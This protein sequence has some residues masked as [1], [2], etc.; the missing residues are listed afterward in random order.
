MK[1]TDYVKIVRTD[2]DNSSISRLSVKL[3]EEKIPI[4]VRALYTY[5]AI[6]GCDGGSPAQLLELNK[7]HHRCH[8]VDCPQFSCRFSFV[9]T[10]LVDRFVHVA[11]DLAAS[12]FCAVSTSTP[13]S[14]MA[15]ELVKSEF[16]SLNADAQDISS[17]FKKIR[18][19]RSVSKSFTCCDETFEDTWEQIIDEP[20]A[21][22]VIIDDA[23]DGGRTA[24]CL[25]RSLYHK[26]L[27][28]EDFS[29]VVLALYSM[30]RH[31]S[32]ANYDTGEESEPIFL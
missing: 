8:S 21:N 18:P 24:A 4:E 31:V 7:L 11:K 3:A 23:V 32:P 30:A 14:Q 10:A 17:G 9:K 5:S 1:N 16:S 6:E 27:F 26:S 25:T 2:L 20:I 29:V 22:L 13:G 19:S 28:S 12:H 15:I